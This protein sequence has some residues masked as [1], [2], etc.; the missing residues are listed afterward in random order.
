MK[1]SDTSSQDVAITP[2]NSRRKVLV[3]TVAV[4]LVMLLAWIS[5]PAIQRWTQAEQSVAAERLRFSQVAY[6]D[7]V[8]DVTVQGRVVA[9]VSPTLFASQAG[10]ITFSV[11]AGDAVI[12][13]QV[14]A[15]IDSPEMQNL[16]LQERSRLMSLQIEYDRQRI[17]NQQ[18]ILENTRAF[19][20]A[21]ISL[22]AAQRE[23]TRSELARAQGA[24]TAVDYERARDNLETAQVMHKHAE[25]NT[26]LDNERLAFELQTR[27]LAVEQQELL[28]QDLARQVD[29]LAILSPVSGIVG[30]L[31]V[32]QK[33]SVARN[34]A[35][36]S[37]VDLSAFEIEVQVP[38]N[39]VGD[40]AIGMLAEVRAG[41]QVQSATL[42][43]V[44]PEI[45][46]N[47]VS[48]RLRFDGPVPDGLRQNQRLTT[49]ILL[50]EKKGVLMVQRGQFLESGSGRLAYRVVDGIAYRT[51]IVIGAT[52]LS[53]VEILDGLSPGDTI[54]VSGT[55][56]FDDAETVLINN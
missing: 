7:F 48:A 53:S 18:E 37:V 24:I 40:L 29:E 20:S 13:G 8:R 19:D 39:Y 11:D 56:A 28:V 36:L 5:V 21:T 47:Q 22:K 23:L 16:L 15:T 41:A 4:A 9:A 52:S 51:P 55:D 44:S 2:T 50:E 30:N 10:T 49:R 46:D 43:A 27:Q 54:I 32:D 1:I 33:T 45:V 34:Q 38:E 35:V 14:L 42:V 31:L 3:V 26:E 6:G 12:E 25:L 17:A